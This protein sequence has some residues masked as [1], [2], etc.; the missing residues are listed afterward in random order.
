MIQYELKEENFAE[1]ESGSRRTYGVYA[2]DSETNSLIVSM[3]DVFTDAAQGER[4]VRE[5]NE[6]EL[7]PI[8]LDEVIENELLA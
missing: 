5:C 6:Y 7:D 4:L 8:H 2:Y 1:E 3:H